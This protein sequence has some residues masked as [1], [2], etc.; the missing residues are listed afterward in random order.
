METN[1]KTLLKVPIV[2][3][4]KKYDGRAFNMQINNT[5]DQPVRVRLFGNGQTFA[6]VMDLEEQ[7]GEQAQYVR[8]VSE[9]PS[10]SQG[11]PEGYQVGDT[12]LYSGETNDQYITGMAYTLIL[13][14]SLMNLYKWEPQM[15]PL[16]M[17]FCFNEHNIESVRKFL[18]GSSGYRF[19]NFVIFLVAERGFQLFDRNTLSYTA[20]LSGNVYAFC[21]LSQC[22]SPGDKSKNLF[23]L[24]YSLL[25]YAFQLTKVIFKIATVKRASAIT[26]TLV[27]NFF[28]VF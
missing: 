11:L 7:G 23:H 26:I 27:M 24:S 19:S 1:K 20:I 25:T 3:L 28:F 8:Q 2:D 10:L 5:G 16:R 12:V 4:Q 13:S 14:E 21:V 9:M 18:L 22:S 17:M 6:E 15:N